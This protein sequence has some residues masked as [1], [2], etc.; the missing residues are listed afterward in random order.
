MK[1][2]PKHG[3]FNIS[4]LNG[5]ILLIYILPVSTVKELFNQIKLQRFLKILNINLRNVNSVY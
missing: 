2:K 3:N 5:K 4:I 1:K